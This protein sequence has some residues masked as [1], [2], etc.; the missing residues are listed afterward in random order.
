MFYLIFIYTYRYCKHFNKN[1]NIEKGNIM[2]IIALQEYT[3]KYVS[4]YQGEIRNI[5]TELAQRLIEKG[6]VAEHDESSEGSD[7]GSS[8][9]SN[10]LFYIVNILGSGDPYTGWNGTVTSIR[11]DKT[12]QQVQQAINNDKIVILKIDIEF[13][14]GETSDPEAIPHEYYTTFYNGAYSY[15]K[16][17]DTQYIKIYWTLEGI[18][19]NFIKE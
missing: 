12:Y 5:N 2:E 13:D 14:D 3:D 15:I 10:D 7:S 8:N 4:F 19:I 17:N 9:P 6:V 18:N 1:V 11:T 16:R